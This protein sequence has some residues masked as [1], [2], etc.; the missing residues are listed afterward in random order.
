M[1]RFNISADDAHG[2]LVVGIDIGSGGTRA[3]VYDVS[4]REVDKLAHKES[5]EFTVGDD[6]A[7]TIDADQV[8][9]EI[10][11]A[12]G[13]VLG[14][15]LPGTVRGIGFDTFASSLVAVDADGRAITPCITYADTRCHAQVTDLAARLDIDELHERTG[16]RLHSSYT[17]PR[18]AWLREEHPEVFTRTERFM[19]LGEYV[20]FRL[21]GTAALGTAS[22]AWSGMIDRR[23]G[24]YVP[25][26]LEAIGVQAS[27]LGE[28]LDPDDALPVADTPLAEEFP[29][30]TEAVWL[31]VIGD[32]L[33]ANLGI[34]ALGAGTWGISTAT[35]GAIRQLLDTEI[36]SLP[37]GLWAYRVDQRRTLVGSAMSDCGRVLDWARFQLGIPEDISETDTETLFSAPPSNGTPLVIPFFS[38]ERG[39]KWRGSSR[40]LFANVGASTT[41]EDMLRG[42]MEGVALS[43][44]RIADQMREAGG[45]PERIVLS[46]GMTEAIPAWLHLL[47]DALGAPID[48]V[49]VSRSTMRG[50]AVMALEQAS[51][52]T[53][54]AEAPVLR[55]VEPVAENAAYYRE[56]LE[57]FEKLADLA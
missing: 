13:V 12:L 49:A 4:G 28:A 52:G 11:T 5:H 41:A 40:A 23:T 15:E 54:V 38:G 9:E 25:E 6:G 16:A 39:T 1:P 32:G 17:A 55:R 22:A 27:A 57:R 26:V 47:A 19:A 51:P 30:I 42:A 44:L 21:L 46:G 8:V 37:S 10:R 31:P 24:Q 53:A 43:F 36:S 48:H 20:A 45:E 56:R 50:S 7:S 33:A 2:P 34:G 35:S 29:Q 3:A 18:L 14:G